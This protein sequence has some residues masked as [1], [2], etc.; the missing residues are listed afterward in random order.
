MNKI[1]LIKGGARF[2]LSMWMIYKLR[3]IKIRFRYFLGD[4]GCRKQRIMSQSSLKKK[5]IPVKLL[6]KFQ[7]KHEYI[8]TSLNLCPTYSV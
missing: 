6:I 5:E 4:C 1:N 3:E 2:R 7:A 8:V